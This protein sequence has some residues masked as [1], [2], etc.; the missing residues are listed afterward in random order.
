MR[1]CLRDVTRH[2]GSVS[3]ATVDKIIP[4]LA[5]FGVGRSNRAYGVVGDDVVSNHFFMRGI[6]MDGSHSD[7]PLHN[8]GTPRF[9]NQ[10]VER[11]KH[12][13]RQR[14]GYAISVALR[15]HQKQFPGRISAPNPTIVSLDHKLGTCRRIYVRSHLIERPSGVLHPMSA[16]RRPTLHPLP[17]ERD[18]AR[19]RTM[20][21]KAW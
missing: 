10:R 9:T 3:F 14:V 2:A 21:G 1:A 8:A 5:V 11:R 17:R 18:R 15:P 16:P 7:H 20:L 4:T 13:L 12:S 6:K 19:G